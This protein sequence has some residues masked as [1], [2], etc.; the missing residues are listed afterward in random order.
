MIMKLVLC[1]AKGNLSSSA[2]SI[3]QIEDFK[4]LEWNGM[5]VLKGFLCD[6]D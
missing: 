3:N 2:M 5:E 6:L 1:P 4:M